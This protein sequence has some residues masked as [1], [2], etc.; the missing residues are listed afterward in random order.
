MGVTAYCI[1]TAVGNKEQGR[2]IIW[3]VYVCVFC[4]NMD[5]MSKV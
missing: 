2:K 5:I 1:S 4:V 3:R